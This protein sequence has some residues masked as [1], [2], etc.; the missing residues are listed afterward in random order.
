MT[1]SHFLP[2]REDT[3]MTDLA[4]CGSKDSRN[5]SLVDRNAACHR[6]R[7]ERTVR[8]AV[9]VSWSRVVLG[10]CPKPRRRRHRR[11]GRIT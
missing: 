1:D 8:V 5:E 7:C 9:S 2:S 4:L 11:E 10:G 3:S 6:S